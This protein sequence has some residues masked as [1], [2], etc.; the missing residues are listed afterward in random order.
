VAK[1]AFDRIMEG[2]QDALA[3]AKGDASR[4][5][6]VH[7]V[8]PVDVKTVREKTGLSQREFSATFRIPLSTLRKWE[9]REREPT[10]P[11]RV[12]LH[13]I[14]RKPKIVLKVAREVTPKAA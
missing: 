1:K 3:Y 4:V 9:Q 5:G 7:H 6:R 8:Y 13:V 2:L 11:A 10:G 14:D 12:L